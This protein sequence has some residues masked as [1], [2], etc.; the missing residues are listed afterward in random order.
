ML[1]TLF[2]CDYTE[3]PG[4]SYYEDMAKTRTEYF[5]TDDI[6]KIWEY[7]INKLGESII[8]DIDDK[9]MEQFTMTFTKYFLN[10]IRKYINENNIK[11]IN[12]KLIEN[13]YQQKKEIYDPTMGDCLYR[14]SIEPKDM[15][16]VDL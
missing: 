9:F 10:L 3:I 8:I 2:K 7:F 4:Y 5:K 11:E 1:Y 12:T 16:I 15:E 14:I 13:V 6:N